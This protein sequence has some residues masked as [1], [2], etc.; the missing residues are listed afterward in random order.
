MGQPH[1]GRKGMKLALKG[2]TP[3]LERVAGFVGTTRCVADIGSDHGLLPIALIKSERVLSAIAVERIQGPFR[4]AREAALCAGVEHR[5]DVRL[6]DGFSVIEAHEVDAVVLAGMGGATMLGILCAPAAHPVLAGSC[7]RLVLQPMNGSGLLRHFAFLSGYEIEQDIRVRD[8]GM[9]YGCLSLRR[10]RGGP[11]ARWKPPT[12]DRVQQSYAELALPERVRLDYGEQG[13]RSG[14]RLM[15]EQ[16]ESDVARLRLAF[17]DIAG[18]RA[19]SPDMEGERM[20]RA[21]ARSH[22]IM[23]RIKALEAMRFGVGCNS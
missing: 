13:L 7:E 16:M 21:A 19:G 10:R 23:E 11:V 8:R 2:L 9:I 5:V 3:R 20:E 14:C 4:A 1:K 15:R 22:E 6:G 17:S 12:L 18:R